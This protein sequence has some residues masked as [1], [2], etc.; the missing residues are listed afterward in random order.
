[1][2]CCIP[3]NRECDTAKAGIK[4]YP[5][6]EVD[7][8]MKVQNTTIFMGDVLGNQDRNER[9]SG[10]AQEKNGQKSIFAGDL[11]RNFD[12]IAQKQQSARKKV[13]KIVGDAWAGDQVMTDEMENARIRMEESKKAMK[14]A[15]AEIK[16]A[17]QERAA[18]RETYGVAE[19]SQEQQDLKLLEKEHNARTFGGEFFSEE[20]QER[21]A[22][23]HEE[24]LTQYQQRSME[25]FESEDYYKKQLN[26]AKDQ[27]RAA[28][29]SVSA[30]R[31]AM[32]KN[33]AMIKA[34]NTAEQIMESASKEIIGMLVDEAKDHIDEEME[35]K[36]EEALEKAE[37]EKEEEERIE[38]IK[39]EK[40][41]NEE[42]AEQVSESSQLFTEA[43]S[44]IEEVQKAIK[45]VMDEMKLLEEDIKGAAVDASM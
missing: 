2:I 26:E 33:K 4:E 27:T 25:L 3:Q 15:N 32:A 44:A 38:K 22:Q 43:D 10:N 35:E 36:K 5:G 29:A 8:T 31:S 45:K 19:D 11:S 20:E 34:Q 6:Q 24:G 12:P 39:E 30:I 1:M 28:N 18:L 13:M 37:K 17:E 14:E 9:L 21:L 7:G 23:I 40:D 41:E 42:F 16:W